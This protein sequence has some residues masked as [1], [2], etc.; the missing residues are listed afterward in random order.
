M[1]NL[2]ILFGGK[3]TEHEVSL[4]SSHSV[5]TALD[6]SRYTLTTVGITKE[7]KWYLYTGDIEKIP[8]GSWA[9]D[10][11]NLTPA[12]FKPDADDPYLYTANG[13]AIPVDVVF[14]V[15]HGANS[16]DG[17]LQGL[18]EMKGLPFV[19]PGC[20]SSA[21]CMDKSYAKLILNNIDIPMA[22]ALTVTDSEIAESMEQIR[23]T[24]EE[25][26]AYPVFVK[27]ANAGSSVGVKKAKN[28][29]ALEEALQTAAKFDRKV[30]IE[31]FIEGR[32]IEVAVLGNYAKAKALACGEVVP[33]AEFYD[34]DDKYN[35]DAAD[36]RVP[37]PISEDEKERVFELA[38]QIYAALD[39]RG[40]SRVDFFLCPDGSF[41]FNEIN[42]LPGF[43]SISLYPR[44]AGAA[45]IGYAELVDRL[46]ELAME[47]E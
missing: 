6:R 22:E 1:T 24:V 47:K 34:Y 27:P 40:L 12:F 26:Y 46:V 2:C 44:L 37:A 13:R 29:E 33:G 39:C 41:V 28:G 45:G 14:P 15:M 3:S 18:F 42:T 25:N 16:E 5:M 7:G 32:E 9:A 31:E 35:S 10:E 11:A 21:V 36:L 43:T 38:E 19:G 20:A 8:D 4:R 30:L 17:T 23:R